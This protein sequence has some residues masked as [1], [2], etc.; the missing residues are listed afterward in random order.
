MDDE[1]NGPGALHVGMSDE[2]REEF[3]KDKLC[4]S[5]L[6]VGVE[7]HSSYRD[8]WL[9]INHLNNKSW[10]ENGHTELTEVEDG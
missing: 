9:E 4:A 2:R 5:C 7:S 1:G 3:K 6:P 10:E 8:M